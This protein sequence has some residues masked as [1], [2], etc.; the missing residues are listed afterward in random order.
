MKQ[1]ENTFA[2]SDE[3]RQ[4]FSPGMKLADL[5]ESNYE[6]LAILSRLSIPLGFGETSVGEMCRRHNLS[7][8]LFLLICRIYSSA[9]PASPCESL[10]P[11]DLGHIMR[12]LHASHVYYLQTVLPRLDARMEAMIEAC[13]GVH[14]KILHSFFADYRREVDN[15]F[16]YEERIVFPYVRSLLEGGQPGNYNI[17]CFED[18]HS[19]IDGKLSD[20]KSIVIKYLPES[21]P[22]ELRHEVLF[23]IFR[24]EEDLRKHTEIENGI[25]IPLVEKLEKDGKRTDL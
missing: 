6:L 12:Y 18:N 25:L 19:D 15:H 11:A 8:E 5:I 21:C 17:L 13:E 16:D 7:P 24:F 3:G 9:E 20:L 23:E 22:A 4:L 2:G 14:R 10:A 1:T